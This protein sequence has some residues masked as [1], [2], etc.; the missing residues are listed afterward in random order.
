MTP[1]YLTRSQDS[2]SRHPSSRCLLRWLRSRN[3]R[4]SVRSR[5]NPS[6]IS[7]VARMAWWS[8]TVGYDGP[9]VWQENTV[10]VYLNSRDRTILW[11]CSGVYAMLQ[12]SD[13]V[14]HCCAASRRRTWSRCC[15]A[16][17]TVFLTM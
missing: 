1:R 16:A 3:A 17:K 10:A 4:L 9:V 14:E 7:A 12:A 13:A 8:L 2:F 15:I 11:D 5:S 6:F